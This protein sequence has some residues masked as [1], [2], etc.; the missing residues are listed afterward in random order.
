MYLHNNYYF[1]YQ[2]ALFIGPVRDFCNVRHILEIHW[3]RNSQ[4]DVILFNVCLTSLWF[5][6]LFTAVTTPQ[7]ARNLAH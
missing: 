3:Q 7:G 5:D 2:R 1:I 4:I 6:Q